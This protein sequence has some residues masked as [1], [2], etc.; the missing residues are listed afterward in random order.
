MDLQTILKM[1]IMKLRKNLLS[2]EEFENVYRIENIKIEKFNNQF[3][4][5]QRN[6]LDLLNF[7]GE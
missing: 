7:S 1:K 6:I 4:G 2:K 5:K 3:I